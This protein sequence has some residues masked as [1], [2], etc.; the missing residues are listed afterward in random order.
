[1]SKGGHMVAQFWGQALLWT[2]TTA[3]LAPASLCP[4]RVHSPSP[5]S[6]PPPAIGVSPSFGSRVLSD[7]V[8]PLLR[9]ASHTPQRP[10]RACGPTCAP[11]TRPGPP[12]PPARRSSFLSDTDISWNRPCQTSRFGAP[13]LRR[14]CGP[15]A[16]GTG[17]WGHA[18]TGD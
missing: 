12:S 3:G 14:D 2:L 10:W 4:L 11:I 1:M 9:V 13:S 15:P 7:A 17:N 6:S 5:I 8:A 18:P 16:D